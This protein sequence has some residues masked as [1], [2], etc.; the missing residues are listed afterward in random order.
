MR[1]GWV[2]IL[3]GLT[4]S[5]AVWAQE[6]PS[7]CVEQGA[8]AYDDWTKMDSG[9]AGLPADETSK[10]YIRCKACHGWDRMGTDGGYVRR[11]RKDTRPNAGQGD[12]DASSRTITTGMVTSDQILHAGSGRSYADG[13]G[14]WVALDVVRSAANTAANAAGYTLGNQH[15]DFSADG[16]PTDDQVDC[17]VEFLN[18]ADGDPGLYFSSI[19]PT[20]TPVWYNI[21]ETADAAMGEIFFEDS[22]E[23]CHGAPDEFVLPYLE[24]DGKFSEL[25]HKARWGS[26]DTAMTRGAMGDPTAQNISDMLLF[27]QEELLADQTVV[28]N[29]GFNDAWRN[30]IKLGGQ[31]VFIVVYPGIQ[32]I[33][34][35]WFTYDLALPADGIDFTIGDP[36]QRWYT[37]FGDYDGDTA[38]L[39]LE[40]N[41]DG[42][43]D[44]ATPITQ[45]VDGTVTLTAINCEEMLLSYDIF[46]A[47]VQGDIP[48]G[49]V[50]DDKLEDCRSLSVQAE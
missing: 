42:I 50:T 14:S 16:G 26:P 19:N 1:I 15:P 48:L 36:G 31:G 40:L 41:Q 11:S 17:L 37:A 9:G 22:C 45:T 28:L 7:A 5:T 44:S 8:L 20:P 49:R 6:A 34:M 33:F 35:S 2:A 24:G 47:D 27:L 13:S 23:G 18:F 43:F 3:A 21:V 4:L 10:D 39:D 30:P 32:K 38:V 46:S 29:E 12:G 25:A